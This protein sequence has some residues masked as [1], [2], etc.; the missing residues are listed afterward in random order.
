MSR[1]GHTYHT[2][3]LARS[4]RGGGGLKQLLCRLCQQHQFV[5]VR[6]SFSIS[7]PPL[8][9]PAALGPA[10]IVLGAPPGEDAPADSPDAGA[11]SAATE[12]RQTATRYGAS[13]T[14]ARI[15]TSPRGAASEGSSPSAPSTRQTFATPPPELYARFR[16][17]V[18]T[19]NTWRPVRLLS[20]LL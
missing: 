18:D 3:C 11:A 13:P 19:S 9:S 17:V 20:N 4:M 5:A 6:P 2:D 10:R 12:A 15:N 1:C 14:S 16:H 7:E 8:S